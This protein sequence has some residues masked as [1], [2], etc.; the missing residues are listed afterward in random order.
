MDIGDIK[1]VYG[2]M[3][4]L[5]GSIGEINNLL[6]INSF[7]KTYTLGVVV[8]IIWKTYRERYNFFEKKDS[9]AT[10]DSGAKRSCAPL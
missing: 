8:H 9:L 5:Y 2:V 10:L 3:G 6:G 7:P 4:P 1:G